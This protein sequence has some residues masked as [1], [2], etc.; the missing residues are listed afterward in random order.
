MLQGKN[1]TT[2]YNVK[3]SVIMKKHRIWTTALVALVVVLMLT[4]AAFA[5]NTSPP[6]TTPAA[7]ESLVTI[8]AKE[9]P[10]KDNVFGSLP[11][12]K[13]YID[14]D[15]G[16]KVNKSITKLYEDTV[17]ANKDSKVTFSYT[18]SG[19][20][21]YLSLIMNVE[22]NSGN[23]SSKD[24]H[25]IV[26]SKQEAKICTLQDI[27]S[28]ENAYKTATET[29]RKQIAQ[30]PEKYLQGVAGKAV[31]DKNTAFYVDEKSQI[32]VVFNKYSIAPGVTGAPSFT[33]ET[34]ESPTI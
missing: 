25:T 32:V 23:T 22:V 2:I 13:T 33:V 14:K 4:T 12:L 29:V 9:M 20:E 18:I 5:R 21:Q 15:I 8:I 28:A 1:Q 34:L 27:M 11:Y 30:H 26:L 3:G 10:T 31:V 16:D 17:A 19:D 24:V 7:S 6:K